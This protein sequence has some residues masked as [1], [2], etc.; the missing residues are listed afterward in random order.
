MTRFFFVSYAISIVSNSKVQTFD[1]KIHHWLIS[2]ASN[3]LMMFMLMWFL[4]ST[5]HLPTMYLSDANLSTVKLGNK[6][7]L[8]VLKLFLNAKSSLSLWS[9]WQIAQWKWFFNTNLFLI[10]PFLIAK[11]DCIDIWVKEIIFQEKL[12]W[13]NVSW[14][15]MQNWECGLRI[16]I[17]CD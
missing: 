14:S 7:L 3:F 2:T 4:I 12:W 8:V 9:K 15:A 13:K 17:I 5:T 10:K 11:F 6:E 1:C 16:H